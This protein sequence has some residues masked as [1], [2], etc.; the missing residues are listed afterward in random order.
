MI[1]HAIYQDWNYKIMVMKL[2]NRVSDIILEHGKWLANLWSFP[3]TLNSPQLETEIYTR[4]NK[5]IL[6][7][8]HPITAQLHEGTA[9]GHQL[10]ISSRYGTVRE[11]NERRGKVFSEFSGVTNKATHYMASRN[12]SRGQWKWAIEYYVRLFLQFSVTWM[13]RIRHMRLSREM[14]SCWVLTPLAAI[15]QYVWTC[16]MEHVLHPCT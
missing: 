7:I 12:P 15:V 13:H 6:N 11:Y 3:S 8:C 14:C 2:L 1:V 10:K 16:Q 9:W 4:C 5:T